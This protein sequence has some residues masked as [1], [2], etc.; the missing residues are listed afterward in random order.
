MLWKIRAGEDLSYGDF[1]DFSAGEDGKLMCQGAV[2]L[3][4]IKG[5]AL[6]D[7][8]EGEMLIL[9]TESGTKDLALIKSQSS[10]K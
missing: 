1:V 6:R 4:S 9:D 3:E 8:V 2:K 5:I 7:A 10:R